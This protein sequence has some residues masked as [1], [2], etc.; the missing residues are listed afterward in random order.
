MVVTIAWDL[1]RLLTALY[2]IDSGMVSIPGQARG[3]V[4][5]MHESKVVRITT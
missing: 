2:G 4:R 3:P 5:S 1:D